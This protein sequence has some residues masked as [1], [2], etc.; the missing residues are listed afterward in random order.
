MT[1][2]SKD[3]NTKRRSLRVVGAPLIAANLVLAGL[4][5]S[6]NSAD[7]QNLQSITIGKA[8]DTIPFTVVDV[9][10]DQ[11]FFKKNGLDVKE[12]LVQGSS[13]ASAAMVGGSLQFACE[14]AV[15]LM[16]ARSHGVP[17]IA[18]D[19]L[20]TGVTLQFLASKQWLSK[21]PV[22][23]NA[24]FKQKM[25]D[26]NGSVL[27]QVGTTDQAFYGLLRGWAGL[28]PYDGYRVEQMDSEAAVAVAIQKGI[29][30]VTVQSPPHSVELAQQGDAVN[31]VDRND[32]AQFNDVA[33][34]LLTTT[35]AYAKQ[36]PKITEAVAT[37]IAQTLN[38]IRNHPAETLAVEQ[39][40]FPKL[41]KTVLQK[42]LE[43]I[44]FAK[45]GLQSQKAWDSAVTLAQQTGFVK[46]VKA[47][48]EGDYWTNKYVDT[49]K[50]GR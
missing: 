28:P 39:R 47:A 5:S 43:F 21:H 35:T 24:D 50:L 22:P 19:A 17:I 7:A 34:D 23:A 40:H 29:V 6:A 32:V 49:S 44:P 36:N 37:S 18:V 25:T 48:P 33:Y 45:D 13:A 3:R 12:V 1:G 38:F 46:D 8:V 9:A 41:D 16:L 20:D 26:L 14:A 2:R 10:I 27:G 30:D 42:S 15:P 4:C 11:G 31:F